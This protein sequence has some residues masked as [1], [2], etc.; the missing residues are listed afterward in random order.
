LY[1]NKDMLAEA[2]VQPPTTWDELISTAKA[3]TKDDRYGIA[4][5]AVGTEE[6]SFQFEPFFWTAGA[7]LKNLASPQAVQALTLWKTLVDQGSASK[8]VVTY[9]Q[10]DIN[11]QF[12]A[13][14][15]AMMV[16]GPWQLP[17]LN[18]KTG[19]NFG[20]VPIPIPSASAKP[21]TPMGGEV[22]TVGRSN[23]DREAKA[24]A[25]VKCLLSADNSATWSKLVGYVPSNQQAASQLAAS[26]PQMAPF[27]TEVATAQ[28]RTAELGT[29]YPKVSEALWTA[30]QACLAGGKSPQEALQAAQAQATS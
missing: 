26:D 10:A 8:S 30:V 19:L 13:G 20:I 17:N 1:Y 22:W 25:V 3:L 14:D 2:K 15:L 7:S 11:D 18:A 4:F 21:V 29:Q 6:G 27:V 9:T 24:I 16:N 23:P 12:A 28:A 5:S